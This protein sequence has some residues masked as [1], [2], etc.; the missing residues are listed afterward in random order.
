[1]YRS[2][3]HLKRF[4][5]EGGNVDELE[6]YFEVRIY[7]FFI[8]NYEQT[9]RNQFGRV[10]SS[11]LV[12]N[13]SQIKVNKNNIHS[14][15]HRLSNY[16]QNIE[17]FEQCRAFLSGFRVMIPLEWIRMFN[18][19]ELQL[20]ISGDQRAI[21]I[22]DLKRNIYYASGYHESQ[23]YIADLWS[24]ISE[25]SPV[26][27]GLFLKFVTSC[28]RQPLLGFGQLIPKFCIQQVPM[29]YVNPETPGDSTEAARLPS[30]A[31]WY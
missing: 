16:K 27:Q 13:G 4:A 18:T 10:I 12:P 25:I 23:P 9:T 15:I 19:K 26:D 17:I 6:L 20:L 5:A 22:D 1:M 2:L 28:S 7:L 29:H 30:A 21:D 3:M 24:I 14:Y 31:T 8:L 11:D